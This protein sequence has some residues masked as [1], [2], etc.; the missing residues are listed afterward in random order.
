MAPISSIPNR[1]ASLYCYTVGYIHTLDMDINKITN[2]H[3]VLLSTHRF[4]TL[5]KSYLISSL[6]IPWFGHTAFPC[7]NLMFICCPAVGCIL[8][9][10]LIFTQTFCP[11]RIKCFPEAKL[12]TDYTSHSY[13]N[14]RKER[15]ARTAQ[16]LENWFTFRQIIDICGIMVTHLRPWPTAR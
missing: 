6:M 5:R 14:S 2:C 16:S 3:T 8:K 1:P 11:K 12:F 7:V 13:C 10:I 4:L 9:V 15:L